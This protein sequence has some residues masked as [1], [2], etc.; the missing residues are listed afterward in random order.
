MRHAR[1]MSG[2]IES[3]CMST[4]RIMYFILMSSWFCHHFVD[5]TAAA[6]ERPIVGASEFKV[7]STFDCL[8]LGTVGKSGHRCTNRRGDDLI[9][10][11]HLRVESAAAVKT[12]IT[13]NINNRA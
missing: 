13:S 7:S 6:V 2:S 12:T 11:R 1:A 5:H 9:T 10:F 8:R 4:I 3:G